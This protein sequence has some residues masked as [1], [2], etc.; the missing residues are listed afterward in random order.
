[1][2][3]IRGWLVLLM[4]VL[5]GCGSDSPG[6]QDGST[7][8]D[9]AP[10][11]TGQNDNGDAAP[12]AVNPPTDG[13]DDQST[14]DTPLVDAS[15]STDSDG[16]GVSD[17]GDG[18]PDDPNKIEPGMCGC[19]NLDTDT[20]SD[21]TAD[22]VDGCPLDRTKTEPGICGCGTPDTDRDRDG[23]ADCMDGCPDDPAKTTPGV[24]GCGTPDD[25]TDS[26]GAPGCMDVCPN[27][28]TATTTPHVTAATGPQDEQNVDVADGASW[29]LIY[30]FILRANDGTS[31]YA[32]LDNITGMRVRTDWLR[33]RDFGFSLPA[34]AVILGITATIERVGGSSDAIPIR[35]FDVRLYH[36]SS[37][38]TP[39]N[40]A[41]NATWPSMAYA[42]ATY[43]GPA[44]L[45]G[46]TWT[47]A[48]I[49]NA[50]FGF[51][52]RATMFMYPDPAVDLVSANPTVD[53]VT[54][55]ITYCAQ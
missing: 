28:A 49:N 30:S 24:C 10:R 7:L 29:S 44:D 17:C 31:T 47:A 19:G 52:I 9:V 5:G 43:G 11:D 13:A 3:S 34:I 8:D 18:C 2:G 25:D 16:D 21:G 42:Y 38:L 23:R 39:T 41:S 6:N 50:N 26:D 48:Q 20:D 46:T 45:W 53:H 32:N 37:L 4:T 12:D 55:A 15:C 51:G 1:M 36:G 35:D 27:D 22:C 14:A 40:H 54:L 33:A